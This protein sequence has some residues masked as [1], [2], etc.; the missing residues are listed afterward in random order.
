MNV[1]RF[2]LTLVLALAVMLL[3]ACG[4][5]AAPVQP[6]AAPAQPPAVTATQA[7]PTAA[8][9]ASAPKSGG[10]LV[11]G[12]SFEPSGMDPHADLHKF[13]PIITWPVYDTLLYKNP[14]GTFVPGL[15]TS[16]DISPDGLTYTFKLRQ[17]VKF[18]DGTPF[19]AQAVK[20]SF[21]RIVDPATKSRNAVNLIGPHKST[22]VVD[23]YTVK[24]NLKQPYAAFL[25]SASL[26]WLAIVSP[27]AI[28]KWGKDYRL[29]QVGTGPFR[30][31]EYIEK[32]H[33]TLERNPD[34]N[35]GPSIFKHQ[36]APYLD[37]ITFKFVTEDSVRIGTVQT[38]EI[39]LTNFETPP[40]EWKSLESNAKLQTWKQPLPGEPNFYMIN[41]AKPPTDDL[42]VRQAI[43]YGLNRQ[44]LVNTLYGGV[45]SV[46][47]GPLT[48]STFGYNKSV[49]TM[50]PYNLDKAKSL[51]DQAGWKP[52]PDGI[53]VKD[54]QK[55]AITLVTYTAQPQ[56]EYIQANLK[57]LGFQT[58]IQM[59]AP[60]AYIEA[61][62]GS[63]GN[64]CT[65]SV[66]ASDPSMLEGFYVP[67]ATYYWTFY[68][69][70]DI[71]KLILDGGRVSDPAKRADL[72]S[73]AQQKI[74]EQALALPI[75]TSTAFWLA[76]ASL[77]GL[78]FDP[79]GDP[80]FYDVSLQR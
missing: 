60:L 73:Q 77:Q 74:M 7:A 44:E 57:T 34:Y 67:G 17:G 19:N 48:S 2:R 69:G 76:P 53:R 30:W 42:A 4:A 65:L 32:D 71:S 40:Q 61:C 1:H 21:D 6:T 10:T 59:L 41:T 51:L 54:G 64:L 46:A 56:Q 28:Q 52:G 12:L 11:V 43:L 78:A 38:G 36:G 66:N 24:V 20:F 45:L 49:E 25:D 31:V 72:Y 5:P 37:R 9:N 39:N 8:T 18:H 22:D 27:S 50:Y 55:L 47:Y 58:D 62:K 26:T 80:I 16:W 68:K 29:H 14:D 75:Y 13:I 35:W 33:V 79:R 63:K 23:D 15:A 70:D 3:A